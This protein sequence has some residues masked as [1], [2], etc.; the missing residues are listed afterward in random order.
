MFPVR[1]DNPVI[2]QFRVRSA[3]DTAQRFIAN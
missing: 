1:T 3:V 2:A